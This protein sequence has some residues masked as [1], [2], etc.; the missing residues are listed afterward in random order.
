MRIFCSALA[1]FSQMFPIHKIHIF[2]IYKKADATDSPLRIWGLFLKTPLTLSVL[3]AE[4]RISK[5]NHT[6]SLNNS[7]MQ[8]I[9]NRH[10]NAFFAR[11]ILKLMIPKQLSIVLKERERTLSGMP[12]FSLPMPSSFS[13]GQR[14]SHPARTRSNVFS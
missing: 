12:C 7:S 5:G 4:N 14:Y 11:H 10:L 9:L 13:I 2:A 1:N 8:P 6:N 3:C